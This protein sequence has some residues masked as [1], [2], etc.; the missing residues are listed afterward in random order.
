MKKNRKKRKKVEYPFIIHATETKPLFPTHTHGLS[1]CGLPELIMDP[2]ALGVKGNAARINRVYEYLINHKNKAKMD[3]INNGK[4]IRLMLQELVRERRV[5][6]EY[7]Y[8]LRKAPRDFAAVTMAYID[9]DITDMN[10]VQIY[11]EGDDYVLTD[12]YYLNG[13]QW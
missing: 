4:T 1:E 9:C 5:D 11:I 6:E 12:D 8:C 13:I 7:V 3:D 2:L 10:F